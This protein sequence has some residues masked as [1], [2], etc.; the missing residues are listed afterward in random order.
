MK[1]L[2]KNLSLFLVL[3]TLVLTSCE[4]EDVNPDGP[5]EENKYIP[6]A[7]VEPANLMK[8]WYN[9]KIIPYLGE[10]EYVTGYLDFTTTMNVEYESKTGSVHEYYCYTCV[11]DTITVYLEKIDYLYKVDY[12]HERNVWKFKILEI[13]DDELL[14]S[15]IGDKST[16]LYYEQR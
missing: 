6:P 11:N 8:K 16:W 9:T 4:K 10:I 5:G 7:T 2:I 15:T 14:L 3:F 13:S 1:T 12:N